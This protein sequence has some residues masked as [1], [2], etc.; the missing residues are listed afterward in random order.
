MRIQEG[1]QEIVNQEEVQGLTLV[2]VETAAFQ[3]EVSQKIM[4]VLEA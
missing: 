3:L 4:V 2:V 1:Q